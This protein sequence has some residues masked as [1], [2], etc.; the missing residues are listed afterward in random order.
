[1][2][3]LIILFIFFSI[4]KVITKNINL[5]GSKNKEQT[6]T[7]RNVDW[8]T[9]KDQTI[10]SDFM[11][12]TNHVDNPYTE[13]KE[14]DKPE[15]QQMSSSTEGMGNEGFGYGSLGYGSLGNGSMGQGSIGNLK[16]YKPLEH[17]MDSLS[18]HFEPEGSFG[19]S[20]GQ[21]FCD[22]SLGHARKTAPASSNAYEIPAD[23]T[24]LISMTSASILQGVVMSEILAKPRMRKWRKY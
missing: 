8:E 14:A 3:A 15:P 19:F 4:G 13:P 24:P 11:G 5:N 16:D 9:F 21:D 23:Q 20:E 2:D 10:F 6:R 12:T 18:S 1:M 17:R 7:K 22:P